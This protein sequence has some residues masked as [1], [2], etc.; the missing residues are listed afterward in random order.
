M[1]VQNIPTFNCHFAGFCVELAFSLHPV[2]KNKKVFIDGFLGTQCSD[3]NLLD[4]FHSP[5]LQLI[6]DWTVT[7]QRQF[8][9]RHQS[10]GWLPYVLLHAWPFMPHLSSAS[11]ACPY[12]ILLIVA[13]SLTCQV[14]LA[15][16]CGKEADARDTSQSQVGLMAHDSIGGIAVLV[17]NLSC[18]AEDQ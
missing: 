1:P 17:L 4:P 16:D 8:C 11:H 5:C 6:P 14:K 18:A 2:S 10:S 13:L 12:V 3:C 7:P 15:K 9:P